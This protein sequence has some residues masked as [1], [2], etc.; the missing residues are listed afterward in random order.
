MF[1]QSEDHIIFYILIITLILLG[2]LSHHYW[3]LSIDQ[4]TKPAGVLAPTPPNEVQPYGREKEILKHLKRYPMEGT[5]NWNIYSNPEAKF[6][7]KYPKNW[8]IDNEFNYETLGGIKSERRTV[9]LKRVNGSSNDWICINPIR[10][11]TTGATWVEIEGN[12]IATY[13]Q[14]PEV[15]D[16]FYKLIKTFEVRH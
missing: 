9:Y 7:F 14:D 12:I 3:K 6:T 2:F 15:L 4:P 1:K 11:S 13:S 8:V 10:F 5:K 16:V